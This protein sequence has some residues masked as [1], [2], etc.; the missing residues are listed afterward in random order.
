ML[1]ATV[2]H[3]VLHDSH[4]YTY[5][6]CQ[7]SQILYNIKIYKMSEVYVVCIMVVYKV[8]S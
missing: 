7:V 2:I 8:T 6:K 3:A 5:M 4:V 1:L